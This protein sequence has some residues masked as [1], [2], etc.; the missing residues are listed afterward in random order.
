MKFGRMR[1]CFEPNIFAQSEFRRVLKLS[2][3]DIQI[4]ANSEKHGASHIKLWVEIHRPIVHVDIKSEANVSVRATYED[5]RAK[6]LLLP[7]SFDGHKQ[8]GISYGNYPAYDGEVN[9]YPDQFEP[10][11]SSMMFFHRMREDKC[12]FP[13]QIAQQGLVEIKDQLWDPL[14]NLTFGGVLSG[15]HLRFVGTTD[16]QYGQTTFR[17]WQYET[18]EAAR[19]TNLRIVTHISQASTVEQ[20]KQQVIAIVEAAGDEKTLWQDNLRWWQDFWKRS[21]I[22]INPDKGPDDP[23]W[24]I[25]QNYNLF[26]Y[27]LVSGFFA[28]ESSMFNGGVLTF[29]PEYEKPSQVGGYTSDYRRWGAALTAQNQRLL[30]WPH[31]QVW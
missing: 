5:W 19:S 26:R 24:K 13:M 3:R 14:T 25:S 15:D 17:G 31:A 28:Q 10:S 7:Y 20:W 30:Y 1:I 2:E 12:F 27:M 22:V 11:E 4:E 9:I 21:H 6:A 16:G 29:D 23:G 18:A 8:R